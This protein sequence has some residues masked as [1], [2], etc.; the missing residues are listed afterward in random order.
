MTVGEREVALNTDFRAALGGLMAFEDPDITDGEKQGLLLSNLFP[1]ADVNEFTADEL[2]ELQEKAGWYLN[3]GRSPGDDADAGGG[4]RVYSFSK[5]AALV[6]AAFRQ[7]HGVDLQSVE[8]H[9]WSFLALFMDLGNETA[10]N[11]LVSLRKRVKT[12][13][14]TK[15]ERQ[16]ARELGAMFELDEIDDRTHE[17]RVQED[18]FERLVEKGRRKREQAS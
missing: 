14:A 4:P 6:F 5:D 12:G 16:V 8:M 7:T 3:G 10:F 9:W 13:K 2:I 18:E 15:E 11:Q 17:E 1:E